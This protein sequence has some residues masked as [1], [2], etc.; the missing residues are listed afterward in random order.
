VTERDRQ[1]ERQTDRE[2]QREM[3]RQRETECE[4]DFQGEDRCNNLS[5]FKNKTFHFFAISFV[6]HSSDDGRDGIIDRIHAFNNLSG[7][8]R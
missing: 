6:F 5:P 7:E 8:M 1:R 3:Q 2:R 4:R